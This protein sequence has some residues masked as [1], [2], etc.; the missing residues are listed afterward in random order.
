M[1]RIDVAMAVVYIYRFVVCKNCAS[2]IDVEYLGPAINVRIAGTIRNPGQ[3]RCAKC[4]QSH[5]YVENDIKYTVRDHAPIQAATS[6][7][8]K[9]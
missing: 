7:H 2:D 4:G 3:M 9:P 6:Y 1:N 8:E 5:S